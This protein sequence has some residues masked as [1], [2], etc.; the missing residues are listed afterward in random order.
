MKQVVKISCFENLFEIHLSG[1]PRESILGSILLNIFIN[2]LFTF[3][4]EAKLENFAMAAQ[5]T[6]TVWISKH[7]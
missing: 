1:V 4:T 3:L 5:Y 7:H 2:N 6:Q